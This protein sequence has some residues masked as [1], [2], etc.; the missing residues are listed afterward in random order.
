M[1]VNALRVV[2]AYPASLGNVASVKDVNGMNAEIASAFKLSKVTV[3]GANGYTGIE[4]NVYVTDM[5]EPN[6]KQNTFKVTI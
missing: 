4:Y 3:E 5:A 2:F 6:D 1:P